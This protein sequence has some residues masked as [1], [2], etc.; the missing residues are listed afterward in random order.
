[1]DSALSTHR[2]CLLW[3]VSARLWAIWPKPSSCSPRPASTDTGGRCSSSQRCGDLTVFD[4]TARPLCCNLCV[5]SSVPGLCGSHGGLPAVPGAEE[6][7]AHSYA[8]QRP[9]LLP[10]RDAQ[11]VFKALWVLHLS[12]DTLESP[13][14][15]PNIYLWSSTGGPQVRSSSPKHQMRPTS[16]NNVLFILFYSSVRPPRHILF[17]FIFG[18]PCHMS[19]VPC[20]SV[21]WTLCCRH[22]VDAGL[23][24]LRKPSRRS[25]KL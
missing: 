9:H 18:D 11:G 13:F 10:Q 1:M 15:N 21:L 4:L 19:H 2:S 8:L 16:N 3:V 14:F 23:V 5:C 12:K 24:L 17:Y 7:P 6:E 25:K 20:I 22:C